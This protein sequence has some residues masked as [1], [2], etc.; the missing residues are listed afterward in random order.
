MN[1]P[2]SDD[3]DFTSA[4]EAVSL[5]L[6]MRHIDRVVVVDDE[7]GHGVN[8]EDAYVAAQVLIAADETH[9]LTSAPVFSDLPFDPDPDL[10]KAPFQALWHSLNVDEQR[11]IWA[12]ILAPGTPIDSGR[13]EALSAL[14]KIIGKDSTLFLSFQ[15]WKSKKDELLLPEVVEKTLFLF[16]LDMQHDGGRQDEGIN[17][18]AELLTSKPEQKLCCGLLSK[19]ILPG[20][21]SQRWQQLAE[22]HHIGEHKDR[23]AVIAKDHLHSHPKAFAFRLKRV[24]I[25]PSCDELKDRVFNVL[26]TAHEAARSRIKELSIYDFEQIVFQSSYVEGVWEPD[27]LFRLYG[28]FSRASARAA[29]KSDWRLWEL[30]S[31]VRQVIRV[32]PYKPDDAPESSSRIIQRLEL[33]DEGDYLAEHRS[34]LEIGDIFEKRTG[35]KQYMLLTQPCDLMVRSDGK[36]GRVAEGF[37][38]EIVNVDEAKVYPLPLVRL[39]HYFLSGDKVACVRVS[40]YQ[41]VKLRVLDLAVLSKSGDCT[42]HVEEDN[43]DGLSPSWSALAARVR[44]EYTS[45]VNKYAELT[46]GHKG[47]SLVTEETRKLLERQLADSNGEL[48]KPVIDLQSKTIDFGLKRVSRLLRPYSDFVLRQFAGFMSREAFD[49][50]LSGQVDLCEPAVG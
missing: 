25:S 9:K 42:I 31:Q 18:I 1:P 35:G 15:T 19:D 27:T 44:S 14:E 5:L 12:N 40:S 34:P 20:Q 50:D 2:P 23:F 33:Y 46:V 8:F 11:S 49:H 10:W 37:L 22:G 17:I 28:L 6:G 29:A 21:E 3:A 43:S 13:G 38:V 32:G 30:A 26:K 16:D 39:P 4:K 24:A 45:V 36:R 47:K 41:R 48:L 7:C